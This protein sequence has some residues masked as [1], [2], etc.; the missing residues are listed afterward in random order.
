MTFLYLI[1]G[2]G[3][4]CSALAITIFVLAERHAS[5]KR[6]GLP[7]GH[8]PRNY[9]APLQI[10][11][12]LILSRLGAQKPAERSLDTM[13]L[14]PTWGI[15]LFALLI[16]ALVA[17]TMMGPTGEMYRQDLWIWLI[18][19]FGLGYFLVL[20]MVYEVRYDS[21]GITAPNAFF[22]QVYHPWSKFI[23]AEQSDAV[24]YT[25]LFEDGSLRIKKF[26]VGMPSF[27]VF[28]GQL[29]EMN[30]RNASL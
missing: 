10:N 20:L 23:T 18:V 7:D 9:I 28:V 26:L 5:R 12:G 21:E 22:R 1:L 14:R 4:T 24:H 25:L 2:I 3:L 30:R 29:R 11:P 16:L 17:V 19:F 8:I 15:K 27:L 6:D 13:V